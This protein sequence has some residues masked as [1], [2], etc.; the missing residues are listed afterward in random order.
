[1]ALR[2]L[3]KE[4]GV[5]S[6][7]SITRRDRLDSHPGTYTKRFVPTGYV[8]DQVYQ[9]PTP[10]SPRERI[11][12]AIANVDESQ[13]RRTWEEFEYRLDVWEVTNGADFEYQQVNFMS[14][15]TL[16]VFVSV[17]GKVVPVRN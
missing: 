10:Q 1:M 6:A 4:N 2:S 9:P 8:E 5:S 3:L 16:F 12:Q 13:L 14:F 15:R 7:E 11:S 17:K